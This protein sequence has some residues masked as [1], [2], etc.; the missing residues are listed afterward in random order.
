[1]VRNILWQEVYNS[2]HIAKNVLYEW[3]HG[4][5]SGHPMTTIINCLSNQL[6][7]RCAFAKLC[8]DCDFDDHVRLVVYGDDNI[9]GISEAICERFNQVKLTEYF[10]SVGI[11]YTME[12]KSSVPV[13]YRSL[14]EVSFLKRSFVPSP[15]IDVEYLAPLDL[16]IAV[17][18]ARWTSRGIAQKQIEHDNVVETLDELSLHGQEVYLD[19]STKI[20]RAAGRHFPDLKAPVDPIAEWNTRIKKVTKLVKML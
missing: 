15:L 6:M 10:A 16:K 11:E 4:L 13:P 19:W 5:P 14:T 8:P 20:F 18:I 2:R 3:R 7:F 12:D 9:M 1:M 17:D